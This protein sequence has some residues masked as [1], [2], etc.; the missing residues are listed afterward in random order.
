MK[1]LPPSEEDD[2]QKERSGTSPDGEGA[3]FRVTEASLRELIR[4]ATESGCV[5][6]DQ[7]DALLPCSNRLGRHWRI[8]ATSRHRRWRISIASD[9]S[10]W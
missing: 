6:Y 5:T 7:I 3:I 10:P 1:L 8:Y 4:S 9:H 2:E